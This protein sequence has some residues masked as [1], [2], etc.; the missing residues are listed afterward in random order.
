[1]FRIPLDSRI[2]SLS[3]TA[4]FATL[5]AA[6]AA[7]AK[8]PTTSFS[9][10]IRDPRGA[11]LMDAVVHVEYTYRSDLPSYS[12]ATPGPWISYEVRVFD[13]PK[14]GENYTA[15]AVLPGYEMVEEP[16][17]N[18]QPGQHL[19]KVDLRMASVD[20]VV[21]VSGRVLD[22]H[23]IPVSNAP[24]EL[25]YVYR[26]DLP[27]ADVAYTDA[28]GYYAMTVYDVPVTGENYAV[29]IDGAGCS[30]STPML[31][32]QRGYD[33]TEIDVAVDGQCGADFYDPFDGTDWSPWLPGGAQGT[34]ISWTRTGTAV[35]A[36]T[37]GSNFSP[38]FIYLPEQGQRVN[39]TVETDILGEGPYCHSWFT[40]SGGILFGYVQGSTS[41]Y[42]RLH[43][44]GA[45]NQAG[46]N[47]TRM[48]LDCVGTVPG[49]VSAQS[50]APVTNYWRE[51]NQPE[52]YH[53]LEVV[54]SKEVSANGCTETNP[55]SRI[56][57]YW[58]DE[59]TPRIDVYTAPGVV[60]Q[61]RQVG[62]IR[63]GTNSGS[64]KWDMFHLHD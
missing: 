4:A 59:A 2:R 51:N 6:S 11:L 64:V 63:S 1:M 40:R 46:T 24:V 50:A 52:Q 7:E 44:N 15:Y 42:W 21:S 55:C 54:V 60:V 29:Q 32:L 37:T 19:G 27:N 13:V 48:K 58:S 23:G 62:I 5:L 8:V 35:E 14:T 57:G 38:S 45:C 53:R 9:G 56:Q 43:L 17:F 10:T 61:E 25:R 33:E 47:E 36:Y 18:L 26:T 41:G 3:L 20:P 49:C 16:G 31:N 39:F 34:N 30:G 22:P 12:P 28:N